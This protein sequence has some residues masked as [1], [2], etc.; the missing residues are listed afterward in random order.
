VAGIKQTLLS[1]KNNKMKKLLY[2]TTINAPKQKVWDI[3][4]TH[5]TY[6]VWSGAGWEGSTFAGQWK[7]G[8]NISFIS[9]SGEGTLVHIIE[10]NRADNIKAEHI[11]VLQKG[12]EEDRT[13]EAAKT[14]IGS[15][16]EY[17]FTEKGVT[18]L[19]VEIAS[20]PEWEKMFNDGWP[21]ALA[22]LKEIC[23]Q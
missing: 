14:W 17:R 6:E 7:Q 4:L 15:K 12:G 5:G 2:K 21:A 3:M 22:K 11:A 13:S 19:T 18:E 10:L 9:A 8:E 23:E 1:N 20:N 16:E